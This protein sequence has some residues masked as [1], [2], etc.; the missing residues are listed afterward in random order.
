MCDPWPVER[1]GPILLVISGLGAGGSE[2]V[3]TGLANGW[4]RR[5]RE[6]A[7]LTLEGNERPP[8][9]P[10]DPAVRLVPLGIAAPSSNPVTGTIRTLSRIRAIRSAFREIAPSAIVSFIDRTN[11]LAILAARGLRVPVVVSER[12]DPD[13]HLIGAGWERLRTLAYPRADLLVVQTEG[14]R[15]R[16][17]GRFGVPVRTI[18]NPVAAPS[19]PPEPIPADRRAVVAA[20]RL[21]PQK[22]FDLLID[23]FAAIAPRHPDWTLAIW[24]EGPE[25]EALV[26]RADSISA[27]VTFPGVYR[28]PEEAFRDAGLFVLSSRY[29]GF[30]NVLLEAMA[31]GLPVLATD[32]PSGP[33][34]IVRDGE[35]GKLVPAGDPS[36]LARGLDAMLA[37]PALRGRLAARAPEV[38]HR[39]GL[40]AVLDLWERALDE[41]GAAVRLR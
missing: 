39:F 5:G 28:E 16:V 41:A 9:F 27:R 15:D 34:E 4:A 24:G 40:D 22:G 23:A 19:R 12:I 33:G 6:V 37:D 7:I 26:A 18:P 14:V 38:V 29:E 32:C 10:L 21:D 25:R 11:V 31:H 20:G 2:R 35:N 3:V 8:H 30:P 36:A 17:E 13:R 1:V